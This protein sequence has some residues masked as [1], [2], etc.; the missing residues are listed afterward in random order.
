MKLYVL[1]FSIFLFIGCSLKG[2]T[3]ISGVV[4]DSLNNP[5]I[6][7][8]VY[9]SKTTFGVLTDAKGAY[10]LTVNQDGVYEMIA[11]CIG[12]KSNS[13][14]I[15]ADGKKQNINIKLSVNLILLKEVSVSSKEKKR[16]ANYTQFIKLFLG[17]T[18]NSEN[19]K[20]INPEDL[21]L[22]RDDKNK[23][24]NGFSVKPLRIEN[25]A[26]GYYII[27][28]LSDF[29]Y[30]LETGLLKFEGN[31]Y[32]KPLIGSQREIKRWTRNRLSAYYGSRMHF[33]RAF[34]S[35]S[36]GHENFKIFECKIDSANKEFTIIKPLLENDLSLTKTRNYKTV[37]SKN[38]VLISYT[39]NHTEL[40]TGLT[41]FQPRKVITTITFSDFINV[42]QN[43]YFD[44]PYSITWGR[45]MGTERIA[46]MLPYDFLPYVYRKGESV[47]VL[48]NSP[49][50]KY[51]LSQ[52]KK[53]ARDQVFVHIDRNMYTPGDTIH[54]QA[55]IRDRF[56][57]LFE[58]TSVSLYTILFNDKHQVIDSSRFKVERSTSSG[59]L[60]IP[61][62]AETGKYHFVAFT[63]MMQNFDPLDAFQTDISV[64]AKVFD[65]E[66]VEAEFNKKDYHKGDTIRAK[67][68]ISDT[69]G[70]PLDQQKFQ[71]SLITG[72]SSLKTIETH[73]N[74][75][76]ESAIAINIP[77]TIASDLRLQV[78][79][80]KNKNSISETKDFNIP[81]ENQY[82]ELRFLPEGGT[83]VAGLEQRIGFNATDFRGEP[84]SVLG[85]LKNKTGSIID[86]IRSGDYGPG[87][88]VCTPEPGMYV[89]LINVTGKEKIWPLPD[90]LKTGISLSVKPVDNRSF[91]VEIQSTNY[92]SEILTV[93]G[94]LNATIIFSQELKLDK[95]QRIVVQTNQLMSGVAQI[96]LFNKEMKPLSERL[97]YINADKHLKFNIKTEND[98]FNPGQETELAVSVTDGQGNPAEGIFSIAVADSISG[99][100][101][102]LFTPGID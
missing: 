2:Q 66:K 42:Y 70:E 8:S 80:K 77:D 91:A 64:K 23:T 1:S 54:F 19:C 33:F 17:Q 46:D 63:G 99:H 37:Y 101:V 52:Q 97:Y 65:P 5:V 32:F 81:F 9:L 14:F 35:D 48:N 47:N 11:S 13:Q 39:D 93:S 27:Y 74:K 34:F 53:I 67:I 75:K 38:P 102:E 68:K 12:Y 18:S 57:N 15:S 90:P 55:F 72:N 7:A 61:S 21:H 4:T 22:Y 96:I 16:L 78:I 50:E 59:W 28:D 60:T 36:L 58:S 85:L 100:D 25:R 24:L 40:A 43:G 41:G 95:K 10:S 62:K 83:M 82:F 76:G 26:L 98:V 6:S 86:T 20:I 79:T 56:T 30:N 84:V 51:L 45:D 31:H 49:I 89:E 73:T 94:T 44:N 87:L 71:Y 69:R 3:I 92:S 29:S 88:F